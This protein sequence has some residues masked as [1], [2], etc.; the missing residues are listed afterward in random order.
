MLLQ[1]SRSGNSTRARTGY[2]VLHVAMDLL[3]PCI[4][5]CV[6]NGPSSQMKFFRGATFSRNFLNSGNL[7]CVSGNMSSCILV[8]KPSFT[9]DAEVKK[10][11]VVEVASASP[12]SVHG[13]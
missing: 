10:F 1:F 3:C 5:L 9:H 2:C 8:A 4:T 6:V 11:L 13:L 12:N 7:E